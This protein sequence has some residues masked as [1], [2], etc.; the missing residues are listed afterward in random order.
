MGVKQA[1]AAGGRYKQQI[2][3]LLLKMLKLTTRRDPK[4]YTT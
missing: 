4:A 3:V 1:T 2:V